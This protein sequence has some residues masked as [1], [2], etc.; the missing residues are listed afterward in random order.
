[1]TTR[2]HISLSSVVLGLVCFAPARPASAAVSLS[3]SGAISGSVTN[4]DG[5]PQMGAVVMLFNHQEGLSQKALTDENGSFVFASLLPDVYSIR[6]TLASF[7]PAIKNNILVQPGM[8]SVLNVSMAA[9]FSSIHLV[10]PAQPAFMRDDWKWVLRT[11][12]STRPIMRLLPGPSKIA[13]V[14][15]SNDEKPH[16]AVF[17]DTRGLVMF[18][19]GDG[20][21]VAG[22][23]SSADMGTAFALATSL[24][25]SN[26][27]QFAGNV[28]SGQQSGIP[29][30]AFR[31]TYSRTV[32]PDSPQV[33]VTMRELFLP[34]QMGVAIFGTQGDVPMLRS[35]S[36]N[37]DDHARISDVLS[38]QYGTALDSVSFNDHLTYFSPYVRMTYSLGDAGDLEFAFTSGN[39]HP[40]L[41]AIG[42]PD[43][44]LQR[45]IGALALFPLVSLRA[46]RSGVQQGEDLE[47]G[48]SRTMGS[49][50]F[51][52][53][54]Y[55]EAIRNLALTVSEPEGFLPIGD[56]LPD[57]LS[58]TAMFDAGN[59]A[60]MGYIASATQD[61][62][63]HLSATVMYGSTGALTAE[64]NDPVTGDPD[65]LRAM[66][67]SGRQQSL[68]M[69]VVAA[70]PHTGTHIAASYQV[71]DSRYGVP[72]PIYSTGS[73]RPQPGFNVYVRQAIP[74]LSSLPWRMELT[75]DL[76]NLLQQ[77]YLPLPTMDGS[78]LVLMETPRMF[79][80]GLSFIF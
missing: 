30:A 33:S 57:F 24:F 52:V 46:G 60:G 47:A 77:G 40:D 58:G 17:S 29:T 13:H 22:F 79:R 76:R 71:A 55:H 9:L 26:Q 54:V 43:D 62:G 74:I 6:V 3:L 20:T 72:E 31:T 59:F 32:G 63:D 11:A 38:L 49:R 28:G 7:V 8:R 73:L 51:G 42:S 69:R 14:D 80:G 15:D 44:P 70:S 50:K 45:D 2:T 39:A 10:Y 78:R 53:T 64:R 37:F 23:G 36:A 4:T 27:F 75:A 41:T 48:Y 68:T 67:H 61:L 12:G 65:E 21:P 34:D 66:I 19:A 35:I 16:R 5:V 1:M 25:G 18:S 56:V